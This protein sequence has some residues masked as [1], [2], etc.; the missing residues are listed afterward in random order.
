[1]TPPRQQ[2]R[3]AVA[4]RTGKNALQ[5]YSSRKFFLVVVVIYYLNLKCHE[6]LLRRV[7]NKVDAEILRTT[8]VLERHVKELVDGTEY[9]LNVSIRF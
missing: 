3:A 1:M 8:S 4:G 5:K 2:Q 6:I 7:G 9:V